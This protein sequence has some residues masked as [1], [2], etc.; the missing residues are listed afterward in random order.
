M[1]TAVKPFNPP[2]MMYAVIGA[3]V[4]VVILTVITAALLFTQHSG[5]SK[6]AMCILSKCPHTKI[7][8]TP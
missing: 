3:A 6:L 7:L 1:F 4:V 2:V 8:T 5:R